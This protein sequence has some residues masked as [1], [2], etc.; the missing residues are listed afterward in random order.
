MV[1]NGHECRGGITSIQS[2]AHTVRAVILPAQAAAYL[3]L[4]LKLD[5][6]Q[7]ATLLT[8]GAACSPYHG[9][10]Q[11]SQPAPATTR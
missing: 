5:D 8:S 4:D 1:C 3:K 9:C 11:T 2:T 10:Q 7:A 6:A